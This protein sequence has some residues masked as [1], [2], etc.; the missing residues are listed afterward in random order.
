MDVVYSYVG[1]TWREKG[2][3][4]PLVNFSPGLFG[5]EGVL[6]A[7]YM[8]DLFVS[9]VPSDTCRAPE[10]IGSISEPPSLPHSCNKGT[11]GWAKE[12]QAAP[13]SWGIICKEAWA[14]T[15]FMLSSLLLCELQ[16][17]FLRAASWEVCCHGWSQGMQ[18]SSVWRNNREKS[19]VDEALERV[20][21]DSS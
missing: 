11:A 21:F 8:F 3:A 5:S 9:A 4:I 12:G 6:C 15:G 7:Y 2:G 19:L 14:Y 1:R 13:Q 18:H 16:S 10:E 20:S 17:D